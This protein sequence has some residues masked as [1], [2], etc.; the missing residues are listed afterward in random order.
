M[1]NRI[2]YYFRKGLVVTKMTFLVLFELLTYD[3][4]KMHLLAVKWI[5]MY[6]VKW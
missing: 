6:K 5:E 2:F 1:T 3:R 4:Q